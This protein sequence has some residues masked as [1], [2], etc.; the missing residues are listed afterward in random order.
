MTAPV[1]HLVKSPGA[2]TKEGWAACCLRT[3][4]SGTGPAQKGVGD[5]AAERSQ[6]QKSDSFLL[7]PQ[8]ASHLQRDCG[9]MC[10]LP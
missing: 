9:Q 2:L 1:R 7:R 8:G 10:Q 6:V 5:T 3:Q 4:A